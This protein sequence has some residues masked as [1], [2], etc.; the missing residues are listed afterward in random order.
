MDEGAGG[1]CLPCHSHGLFK[2]LSGGS[3]LSVYIQLDEIKKK[4]EGVGGA[5]QARK[6][7][8]GADF[9]SLFLLVLFCPSN[10]VFNPS[11]ESC[12]GA[13]CFHNETKDYG[14]GGKG[15]KNVAATDL[16]KRR[17][18]CLQPSTLF[19]LKSLV[20]FIFYSQIKLL[21]PLSNLKEE[22]LDPSSLTI[23][24]MEDST[25]NNV[26]SQRVPFPPH[27]YHLIKCGTS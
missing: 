9:L 10:L 11:E 7:A 19:S 3:G 8:S 14:W 23:C 20:K 25:K 26:M 27:C 1:L 15:R 22:C 16:C 17:K 21:F 18:L 2:V 6:L 5:G 12:D 24:F 13:I 4:E